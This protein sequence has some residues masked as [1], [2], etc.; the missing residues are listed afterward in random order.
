MDERLDFTTLV[1]SVWVAGYLA[2]ILNVVACDGLGWSPHGVRA[3]AI[4]AALLI[5]VLTVGR[6]LGGKRGE[7]TRP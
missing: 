6:M 1:M 2:M 4:V 5:A 3:A 7:I